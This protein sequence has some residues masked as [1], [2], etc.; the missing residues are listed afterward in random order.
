MFTIL[1][2]DKTLAITREDNNYDIYV[3]SGIKPSLVFVDNNTSKEYSLGEYTDVH[4]ATL[5]MGVLIKNIMKQ[6]KS[7]SISVAS[8]D[9]VNDVVSDAS[10]QK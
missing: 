9:I 3:R 1:S 8:N 10:Q 4:N 5:A 6:T 2:Q 7:E